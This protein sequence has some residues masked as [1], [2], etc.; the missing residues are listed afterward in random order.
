LRQDG[1][2]MISSQYFP[3]SRWTFA[4][5]GL[6]A[7][8]GVLFV[9]LPVVIPKMSADFLWISIPGG[10][11]WTIFSLRILR[12]TRAHFVRVSERLVEIGSP[13]GMRILKREEIRSVGNYSGLIYIV[14]MSD[15]VVTLPVFYARHWTLLRLLQS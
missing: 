10:L 11:A 12:E 6:S 9:C 3:A 8:A 7:C 2:D 5:V 13:S 4:F 14:T 1:F 15:E